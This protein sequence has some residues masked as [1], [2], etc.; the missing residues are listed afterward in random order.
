MLEKE[1]INLQWIYLKMITIKVVKVLL[2]AQGQAVD[3]EVTQGLNI[4]KIRMYVQD[5]VALMNAT[6]DGPM[7]IAHRD[8]VQTGS[9]E[10][11]NYF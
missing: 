2:T 6:S 7:Q 1:N 5:E 10:W 9:T 3:I 11:I 4:R 8:A